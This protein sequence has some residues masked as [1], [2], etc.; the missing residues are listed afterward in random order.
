[1][2]NIFFD[3]AQTEIVTAKRKEEAIAD[4]RAEQ[5]VEP[6]KL[7]AIAHLSVVAKSLR[8][9]EKSFDCNR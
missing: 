9:D 1:M 3:A 4:F 2:S 7:F 5:N 6:N 8:L